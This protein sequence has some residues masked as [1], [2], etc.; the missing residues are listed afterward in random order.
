MNNLYYAVNNR[1]QIFLLNQKDLSITKTINI[2]KELSE[3]SKIYMLK[4][5][6]LVVSLFIYDKLN[7][8]D[9][10]NNYNYSNNSKVSIDIQNYEISMN[11]IKW[12]L[13]KEKNIINEKCKNYEETIF[14]KLYKDTILLDNYKKNVLNFIKPKELDFMKK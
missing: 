2:D 13:K 8:V 3:E 5:S 11:G 10:Y 4:L 7:D 12:D 1:N 9:I 6:P 14:I